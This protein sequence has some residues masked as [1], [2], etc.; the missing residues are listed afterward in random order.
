MRKKVDIPVALLETAG[1]ELNLPCCEVILMTVPVETN[2]KE[3]WGQLAATLK[4][5]GR[6]LVELTFK[7]ARRVGDAAISRYI[8]VD[9]IPAIQAPRFAATYDAGH[10]PSLQIRVLNLQGKR[11]TITCRSA[12]HC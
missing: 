4:E 6:N 9:N 2:V 1:H 10:D 3:F 11:I 8:N 5:R 12:Q 7:G